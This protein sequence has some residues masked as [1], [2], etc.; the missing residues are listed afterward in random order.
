[1]SPSGFSILFAPSTTDVW[2]SWG[3]SALGTTIPRVSVLA[4]IELQLRPTLASA[5]LATTTT[6]MAPTRT[7]AAPVAT[8]RFFD[9]TDDLLWVRQTSREPLRPTPRPGRVGVV[10]V[11]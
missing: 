1:M 11:A 4:G 10:K 8:R 3:E 5:E 7:V 9:N 6:A 2:R